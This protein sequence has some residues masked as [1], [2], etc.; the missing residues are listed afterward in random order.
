MASPVALDVTAAS[1]PNG[2]LYSAAPLDAASPCPSTPALGVSYSNSSSSFFDFPSPDPSVPYFHDSLP[3]ASSSSLYI[4]LDLSPTSKN[5][6]QNDFPDS[7]PADISL[8][9]NPMGYKVLEIRTYPRRPHQKRRT[10]RYEPSDSPSQATTSGLPGFPRRTIP[11][12]QAVLESSPQHTRSVQSAYFGANTGSGALA[13]PV[14]AMAHSLP[15]GRHDTTST[16]CAFQPVEDITPDLSLSSGLNAVVYPELDCQH[17]NHI[18][19]ADI[20]MFPSSFGFDD[21]FV[22]RR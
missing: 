5:S 4:P 16:P 11:S 6:S 21:D 13:P 9:K 10:G 3:C 2:H 14:T 8:P 7:P 12:A 22:Q 15:Y 17:W 1:A 18:N 19:H 20:Q